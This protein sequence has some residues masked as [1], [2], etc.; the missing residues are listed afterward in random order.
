VKEK[1]NENS[2]ETMWFIIKLKEQNLCFFF[3]IKQNLCLKVI[4]LI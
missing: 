1:K 2:E 3:L 4:S